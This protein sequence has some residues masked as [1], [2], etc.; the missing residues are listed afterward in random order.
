MATMDTLPSLLSR[1]LRLCNSRGTALAAGVAV[2]GV[3][4]VLL[5][6]GLWSQLTRGVAAE[7]SA[8]LG[9]QAYAE[10]QTHAERETYTPDDASALSAAVWKRVDADTKGLT[11]DARNAAVARV[12]LRFLR[13][14]VPA[15][16]LFG[17]L[18]WLIGLF[19]K[20][21]FLTLFTRRP[22]FLSDAVVLT[23]RA[24]PGLLLIWLLQ[25]LQSCLWLLYV[26]A[27]LSALHPAF[28]LGMLVTVFPVLALYPRLLFAPVIRLEEGKT[29]RQSMRLSFTRT[30]KKWLLTVVPLVGLMAVLWMASNLVNLLLASL[31]AAVLQ[32][33]PLAEKLFWLVPILVLVLTAYRLAFIVE[34]QKDVAHGH[35]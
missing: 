14:I 33:S 21:F 9:P 2:F 7:T 29:V 30:R 6:A 31:A 23:V 16:A 11:P 5:Q 12:A 8:Y 26:F 17:G 15:I 22:L 19:A 34:L 24:F 1:S 4:I 18:V 28:L 13:I 10:V 27:L 35:A 32:Y 25:W 20:A 3:L